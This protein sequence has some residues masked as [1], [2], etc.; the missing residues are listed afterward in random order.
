MPD[1]AAVLVDQRQHEDGGPTGHA[2]EVREREPGNGDDD[3]RREGHEHK[4]DPV[5]E[6]QSEVLAE[7]SDEAGEHQ[8]GAS[9]RSA[10]PVSA[11]KASFR[12]GRVSANSSNSPPPRTAAASTAG[13]TVASRTTT[14]ASCAGETSGSSARHLAEPAVGE[15]M[16]GPQ[17]DL[18]LEAASGD[19][20]GRCARG[21]QLAAV[22]EQEAIAE[23]LGLV[24]LVRAVEHGGAGARESEDRSEHT[25]ARLRI[26]PHRRLV[27]QD[28][29]RPVQDASREAQPPAHADRE[30]RH[31]LVGAV[32]EADQVE[33]MA[34]RRGR[35][36]RRD[37][38][39]AGEEVQVLGRRQGGIER[40]LLGHEPEHAAHGRRLGG[41]TV[42]PD[43]HG[44]GVEAEQGGEDAERGRL[45]R[46]VRTKQSDDLARCNGERE[47]RERDPLAVALGEPINRDCRRHRYSSSH[48]ASFAPA[49]FVVRELPSI[50]WP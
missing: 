45:A 35:I 36:S 44:A 10:R 17:A 1:A 9:S 38:L 11:K 25:L 29:L 4:P 6:E 42:P 33:R 2:V 14:V 37:A 34:D 23:A 26:D 13:T 40:H 19:E 49:L 20:R 15:R 8:S 18:W 43:R 5:A 16:G 27:D 39:R 22:K 7:G 3:H 31:G 28:N 47:S 41:Q 46:A 32:G 30:L 48:W 50:R 24:H 12:F 21:Q